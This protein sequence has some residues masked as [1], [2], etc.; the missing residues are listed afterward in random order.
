[1]CSQEIS[2][3]GWTQGGRINSLRA[4][5]TGQQKQQQRETYKYQAHKGN[6]LIRG[7]L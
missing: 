2:D 1:M 3:R 5:Q 4:C 7:V 6:N